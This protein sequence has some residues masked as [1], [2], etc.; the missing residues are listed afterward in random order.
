M[1]RIEQNQ[2]WQDLPFSVSSSIFYQ[3][4]KF[5]SHTHTYYEFFL[6]SEG[7]LA[8]TKN[9]VTSQLPRRSL[10]LLYPDDEH[11]LRNSQK[12]DHV[13]I[14]NC[15]FSEDF[16][17]ETVGIIKKDLKKIPKSWSKTLVNIPSKNWNGLLQKANTLQ[18]EGHTYSVPAKQAL[19]RSFLLDVLFLLAEPEKSMATEVPA[20]LVKAREQM[21]LE[22]NFIPGLASFIKLSERTQEHLTRSMKKHYQETPTSFINQLRCKKAAQQLLYSRKDTWSIMEDCGFRNYPYFLK[23]FRKSFGLSPKQYIKVN[24]RA[25]TL[26]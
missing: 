13:Q 20:W 16:F 18:F 26:K 25:F 11:E 7:E 24:R 1:K 8:Q 14:I 10:C 23:C 6:V 19:F 4:E 2:F 12:S 9:E 22:E 17:K 21:E 5:I 3:K 15:T